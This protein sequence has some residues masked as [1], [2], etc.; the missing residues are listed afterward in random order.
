MVEKIK[1]IN[2][3]VSEV[4]SGLLIYGVRTSQEV[5]YVGKSTDDDE[6]T[7][8]AELLVANI[9]TGDL[10]SIPVDLAIAQ[11]IDNEVC[12]RG[13][14]PEPPVPEM[15]PVEASDAFRAMLDGLAPGSGDNVTQGEEPLQVNR[16]GPPDQIPQF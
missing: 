3:F 11:F 10:L 2:A 14:E 4:R 13:E 9:V 8:V 12:Q 6:E 1:D 5:L 7:Q 15:K 16:S